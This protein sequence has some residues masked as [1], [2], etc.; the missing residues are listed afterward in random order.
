MIAVAMKQNNAMSE[1]VYYFTTVTIFTISSLILYL[2][3]KTA[4]QQ[5]QVVYQSTS[6]VRREQVN[7]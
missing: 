1:A 2:W 5:Q 4:D 6:L 3:P 7:W